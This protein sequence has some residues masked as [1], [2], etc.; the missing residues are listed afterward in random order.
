MQR[1]ISVANKLKTIRL[2]HGLTMSEFAKQIDVKA[3]SGTVA[4]WETGKNLPNKKR[5]KIIADLA[6][7]T[8]TELLKGGE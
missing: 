5:L 8:V 2:N 7:I 4:N 1:S 6:G 3:K